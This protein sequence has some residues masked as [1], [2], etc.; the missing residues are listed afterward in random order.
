MIDQVEKYKIVEEIG[1]GGMATVYLAYDTRLERQVALKVM[2]PH[3]QRAKEARARFA[4]E[5]LSVARLRHPSILEIYDYS[6]EES[7]HSYIATELL[8]GPTLKKFADDQPEIPAEIAACF[9]IALA[10]ALD[11]AHAQGIIHR[12]VKPEN[13]MIHKNREV[14]LTDF[15]IAQMVDAQ[16]MT[17]TGQVLG[18]PGHMAPE[19]IEGK[20]CDARSDIF[21]LGTVL[22]WLATGKQ[23]FTGRNPHHLLKSI[24]DGRFIDPL[25]VKPSIG[26]TLREIILRCLELDP[27]KRYQSAGE[28][29]QTLS[30]FVQ[31]VGIDSPTETLARYLSDPVG[32]SAELRA[33]ILEHLIV[34]GDRNMDNLAIAFDHFNRALTLD[35][36]NP[37]VLAA[38][39]RI[40]RRARFRRILRTSAGAVIALAIPSLIFL[41]LLQRWVIERRASAPAISKP[42]KIAKVSDPRDHGSA[43]VPFKDDDNSTAEGSLNRRRAEKAATRPV[44]KPAAAIAL[45]KVRFRPFPAN[46]SIGV[47]GASPL[48][49]GPSFNEIE[50]L[51]GLH[52]FSFVGAHECCL[53]EAIEVKIP[54][55]P[56]TTILEHRLRF[57]AAGLYVIANTPADVMVDGAANSGRTRSVIEVPQERELIETHQFLVTAPGYQ[58]YR[59]KVK[60]QAGKV[61]TITVTLEPLEGNERK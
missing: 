59:N 28:L 30:D 24:V 22:Y 45:R 13:V 14:K 12:D 5:A 55:G 56:G 8:T 46:I 50:L 47:D 15:G 10:Q 3:L 9:G 58:D 34:E 25:Q 36:G 32:T 37:R 6:G 40:G 39:E 48:A 31:R 49:F 53:D 41:P 52:R 43:A 4:R 44:R 17:T 60:L 61:E 29:A 2:H 51:P 1:H 19:Q 35:E 27:H 54:A 20:E 57:K 33:Q 18:S 26:G 23:P 16:S 11:A 38:L 7:E 42:F 21:S